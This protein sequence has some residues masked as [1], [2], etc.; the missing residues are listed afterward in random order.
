MDDILKKL[1]NLKY[2]LDMS[3]LENYDIDNK[4]EELENLD[5]EL[6][7]RELLTNELKIKISDLE[8]YKM[9]GQE[10]YTTE[11]E[12]KLKNDVLNAKIQ[13]NE[14]NYIISKLELEIE[15][16]E[17]ETIKKSKTTQLNNSIEKKE[18]L[19]KDIDIKKL[20]LERF[21]NI[22]KDNNDL[23]NDKLKSDKLNLYINEKEIKKIKAKQSII[24]YDYRKELDNLIYEVKNEEL[25][26]QNAKLKF[27]QFV[28]KIDYKFLENDY[29]DRN[30]ELQTNRN[31]QKDIVEKIDKIKLK[32][33]NNDNYLN[34]IFIV[35]R[36]SDTFAKWEDKKE[37]IEN[38]IN[39]FN[40][41]I[42]K[43]ESDQKEYR[44]IA[45]ICMEEILEIQK[46]LRNEENKDLEEKV[47]SNRNIIKEAEMCI[48]ELENEKN[49][50]NIILNNLIEKKA[51]IN[52]VF[53]KLSGRDFKSEINKNDYKLDEVRLSNLTSDLTAL[54]NREKYLST[55]VIENIDSVQNAK[56]T[57]I[58]EIK[59]IK[60]PLKEKIMDKIKKVAKVVL[61]SMATV[62]MFNSFS[63]DDKEIVIGDSKDN[64]AI[65]NFIDENEDF[66]GLDDKEIDEI[67][68][69]DYITIKDGAAIYKNQYDS[70]NK[71]NG[72]NPTYDRNEPREVMGIS[73]SDDNGN[74]VFVQNENDYKDKIN[75]GYKISSYLTSKND[76]PEGFWNANDVT[77]ENLKNMEEALQR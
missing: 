3:K 1:E 13:E 16:A 26:F 71:N 60:R 11:L 61:T 32:L 8:N 21:Q 44:E 34:S 24:N 54:K 62:V 49:N 15:Y 28:E 57:E 23:Y 6:K 45:N 5:L 53:D 29:I 73:L 63:P 70:S 18:K 4:V 72:F 36:N 19:K 75:N 31:L 66:V 22:N 55:S 7:N 68:I 17:N 42:S 30:E 25:S 47:K 10:L 56:N 51:R 2:N 59:V 48:K 20:R 43:I 37:N 77:K 9:N 50:N 74:L 39:G 40:L 69:T 64:I 52:S 76:I 41:E 65:E 58:R 67:K 46:Y 35:E 14:N 12:K 27:D 38:E 33:S